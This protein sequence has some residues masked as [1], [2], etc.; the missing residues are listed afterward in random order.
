MLSRQRSSHLLMASVMRVWGGIE[1]ELNEGVASGPPA[2]GP[3]PRLEHSI[4]CASVTASPTGR[5]MPAYVS[6]LNGLK[7]LSPG[8]E[9]PVV[10]GDDREP[11][12]SRRRRDVAVFHRHALTG[13]LQQTLLLRPDVGDRDVEPVDAPVQGVDQ[14]REPRLQCLALPS[15]LRPHPV[16]QLGDDDGARVAAILFGSSQAITFASPF[17]LAGWQMTSVSSSQLTASAASAARAAEAARRP[18]SPDSPSARR[19]SS[20]PARRRNT[21][22]S[23][24][25]S[26]WASK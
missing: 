16:R 26:K 21:M 9:V 19:A 6:S 3:A 2:A 17:R 10:A 12:P 24:S 22:A 4:G 8:R 5:R 18:G 15:F 1:R 13:L 20:P 7:T 11:V 14:A 23:S 25:A